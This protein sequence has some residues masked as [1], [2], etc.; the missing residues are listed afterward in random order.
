MSKQKLKKEI[1]SEPSLKKARFRTREKLE[2]VSASNVIS[3]RL[4]E[5]GVSKKYLIKTFGCQGNVRDTEYMKGYLD[6]LQMIETEKCD[7]ADLIIFNTCAVRENAENKLYSELGSLKKYYEKNKDLVICLAG[8]VM[9]EEDPYTYIKEHFPYVRLVFGTFNIHNIYSL[10]DRAIFEKL[11]IVEVFS[12]PGEIVENMPTT[13]T[14]KYKAFVNIMYGCDKFCTYCIVPY[15]RG[16]QRSRKC[17]DIIDEV[18]ELIKQGYKEITLVGQ[19]V[20]SYGLDL[21]E[22]EK[23]TFADLLLK[24]AQTGIKRLKFTTS[25]PFD[26]NEKVFDVMKENKNL[27]PWIHLPVQSGSNRVL[28]TM[29]RIYT[30]ERYIELVKLLKSKIPNVSITT[31]IIVGFPSET[32]EDFKETLTLV[33][34]VQFDS[35]YTFIFSPRSGTLAAK[36]ENV[37]K[38][39]VISQRFQL[40]KK[41]VDLITEQKGKEYVG[42]IVEVLFDTISKKNSSMISG[43][44]NHNKLVHVPYQDD[45]IGTIRKVK[46]IE[47][48]TFSFIGEIVNEEQ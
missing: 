17:E 16:Q 7:E 48:H 6:N 12:K 4:K 42:S 18:N 29:N 10:L 28:K 27:I 32:E 5:W 31:D 46:I 45:L 2:F 34:E 9:Q 37:A 15:T 24:V 40:L 33:E 3:S 19:N 11:K 14:D 23:T 38:P 39:E 25:H 13:R 36:M 47:S 43:Y 26:F 1:I 21:S 8:C 41:T 35:A 44:D 30:R 22:G 20:N